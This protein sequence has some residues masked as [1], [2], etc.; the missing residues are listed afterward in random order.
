MSRETLQTRPVKSL[1]SQR[2]SCRQETCAHAIHTLPEREEKMSAA[3]FVASCGKMA[4]GSLGISIMRAFGRLLALIEES[5]NLQGVAF[6]ATYNW[7]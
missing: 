2:S 1:R 6:S 7:V 4:V 5:A 3:P